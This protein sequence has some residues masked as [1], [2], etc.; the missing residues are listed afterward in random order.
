MNKSFIV[1]DKSGE[2]ISGY[3][4][5]IGEKKAFVSAYQ[6]AKVSKGNIF[7]KLDNKKKMIYEWVDGELKKI[8]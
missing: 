1:E 8:E 2:F 5:A 3:N 4:V 7:E 6:C